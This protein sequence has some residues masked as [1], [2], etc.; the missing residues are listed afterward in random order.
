[1]SV[2]SRGAD[3]PTARDATTDTPEGNLELWTPPELT[4]ICDEI[5]PS[6][7][8]V[9]TIVT[10]V[11]W[12]TRLTGAGDPF[13][14]PANRLRR[15]PLAAHVRD[16]LTHTRYGGVRPGEVSYPAQVV[17][18]EPARAL[19]GAVIAGALVPGPA[20]IVG[21]AARKWSED[22]AADFESEAM[23]IVHEVVDDHQRAWAAFL[24]LAV[25]AEARAE[26]VRRDDAA[27]RE[28][29]A[30]A[31]L[32]CPLCRTVDRERH[33]EVSLRT[34]LP[35]WRNGGTDS[36]RIRSVRSCEACWREISDQHFAQLARE[37]TADGSTR[38]EIA[39]TY[40]AASRVADDETVA[41]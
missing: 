13:S 32:E 15:S 30:R 2:F 22:H 26:V 35:S 21:T 31:M 37:R 17:E 40:L 41:N 29:D 34:L 23:T 36:P 11:D 18:Y 10:A 8:E 5:A 1:M 27:R 38:A 33:G 4:A 6:I 28:A 3:K 19:S 20:R 9:V 12:F 7:R 24:H 16:A 39:A 25:I 14:T